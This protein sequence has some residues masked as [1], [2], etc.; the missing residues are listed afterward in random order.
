MAGKPEEDP[1]HVFAH[2]VRGVRKITQDRVTPH[3]P[4]LRPIPHQTLADAKAVLAETL[5]TPAYALDCATGD[6][7]SWRRSGIN[8]ETMRR[9]RRGQIAVQGELD[10]HGLTVDQARLAFVHFLHDALAEGHRCVRIIH[11]K[12]LRSE[13]KLPVLKGCVNGWL[14][15]KDEVLAFCS[16]RPE[17]GGTGAVYVLLK[18]GL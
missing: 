9:M 3:K 1:K 13:A 15:H 7:L 5:M 11:G 17:D 8:T 4:R 6:E 14:Q 12:G 2:A 10:L 16:A 18:R